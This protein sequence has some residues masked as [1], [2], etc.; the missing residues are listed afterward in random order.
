MDAFCHQQEYNPPPPLPSLPEFESIFCQGRHT[1]ELQIAG[2]WV[3]K[4][5]LLL[6]SRTTQVLTKVTAELR[7]AAKLPAGKD[8]CLLILTVNVSLEL[9]AFLRKS[10]YYQGITGQ[11][12]TL[13]NHA[14][15]Q[16]RVVHEY[17]QDPTLKMHFIPLLIKTTWPFISHHASP[18][19]LG[20]WNS[21]SP[22]R[23]KSAV[24]CFVSCSGIGN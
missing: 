20:Y 21:A 23:S 1:Q 6:P 24:C 5:T 15:G 14:L 18:C 22:I 8:S 12:T 16:W 10:E 9:M 4:E 11:T 13:I 19:S 17:P 3:S 7:A 2:W